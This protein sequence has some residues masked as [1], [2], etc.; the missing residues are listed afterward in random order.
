MDKIRVTITGDGSI[1]SLTEATQAD[2]CGKRLP[3]NALLKVECDGY[4][5]EQRKPLE[6]YHTGSRG[7]I[8]RYKIDTRMCT[9]HLCAEVT[10][11]GTY[12]SNS[13]FVDGPECL[14]C[15]SHKLGKARIISYD[16]V[17]C[18]E[19]AERMVRD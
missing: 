15:H 17:Y 12:L 6:T 7:H 13:K 5:I 14:I 19:C 2:K 1:L 11:F 10:P 18:E 3:D 9:I 8:K 16:V 4:I